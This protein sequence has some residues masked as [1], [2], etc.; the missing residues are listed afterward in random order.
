MAIKKKVLYVI[1]QGEWGGAQRYVFDLATNLPPEFEPIVAIGEPKGGS[2][3][4]QK[5]SQTGKNIQIIKLKHLVRRISIWHDILAIFELAK[6]YKNTKP[7]IIHLNSSKAGVVGSLAKLIIPPSPLFPKFVYTVHGWVFNEPAGWLKTKFYYY[8]EKFTAKF[9]DGFILLSE[10]EKLQA[11]NLLKIPNNKLRVIYNG[12][13]APANILSQTG[14]RA[15]IIAL[16]RRQIPQNDTWLGAIANFYPTKGLDI[17]I[18]ALGMLKNELAKVNIVVIGEGPERKNLE[19]LITK[20][21]LD[22]NVFL[23]GTIADAD[24]LLPAFD[25]LILPSRKEGL[26]YT[27][28]EAISQNVPVIA[29]KVGG[30]PDLLT[31]NQTGLLVNQGDVNGLAGAIL[32]ALKQKTALKQYALNAAALKNINNVGEMVKQTIFW[33]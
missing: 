22:N 24:K 17:L 16:S 8:L 21:N 4:L 26:P 15:K 13:N 1:T 10:T 2:E 14:A 25:A 6:L 7:D 11:Q 12:V 33:Y 29:A 31:N 30:I 18:T 3:L 9:K 27:L 19:K 23:T 20:F 28:L 5:L 32:F